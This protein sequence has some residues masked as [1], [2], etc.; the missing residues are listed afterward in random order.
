MSTHFAAITKYFGDSYFTKKRI[1][2]ASIYNLN[3]KG[4]A[5]ETF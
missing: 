4:C 5:M 3:C 2:E 1:K